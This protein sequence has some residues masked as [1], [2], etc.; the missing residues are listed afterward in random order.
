MQSKMKN[1]YLHANT[2]LPPLYSNLFFKLR[3]KI[4]TYTKT[5][6]LE[7]QAVPLPKAPAFHMSFVHVPVAPFLVQHPTNI[8]E[9]QHKMIQI[10]GTLHAHRRTQKKLLSLGSAQLSSRHCDHL[11]SEPRNER[12][13]FI[14]SLCKPA[15]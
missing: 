9:R 14:S 15:F 4:R 7:Q 5:S 11:E 6:F 1:E 10:L 3:N 13:S 2:F 12:T 8:L